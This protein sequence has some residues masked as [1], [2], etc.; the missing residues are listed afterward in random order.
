MHDHLKVFSMIQE[1]IERDPEKEMIEGVAE[2]LG[3]VGDDGFVSGLC[4]TEKF[5]SDN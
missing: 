4:K 5:F 2:G 1:A 3:K